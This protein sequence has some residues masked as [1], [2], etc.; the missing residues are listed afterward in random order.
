[1]HEHVI[2]Y[3]Q[4]PIQKFS[5]KLKKAPPPKKK[6]NQNLNLCHKMHEMHEQGERAKI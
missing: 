1:M 2:T 3:Q 5:Q 4:N 6:K